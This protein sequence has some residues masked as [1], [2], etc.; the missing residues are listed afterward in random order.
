MSDEARGTLDALARDRALVVL[1][2]DGTLAPIVARRDDAA[3]R[4]STRAL[5]RVTSLLYPCAVVSGRSRADLAA[6]VE[7]VPLVAVV[8]NHGAEAGFGPVDR[9]E[10][11]T[12]AAWAAALRG[13]LAGTPGVEIEDKGLS[14]AIHHRQAPDRAAARAR[15]RAAAEALEGARVFLGRAVVNVVP[16]DAPDKGS[17]VREILRRLGVAKALYVGDDVADEDAFRADGIEVAI[18]IGRTH[19]SAAGW[20]LPAQPDIDEL[21]AALVAARRR[22]DGWRPRLSP[23]AVALV[24]RSAPSGDRRPHRAPAAAT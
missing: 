22:R 9:S 23:G 5:L 19:A 12:V 7:G 10:R 16:A 6:R 1:D 3:M 20:Y 24:T 8:G 2:F 18:R 4:P 15:A 17:A 14:V 11:D 21:L 13:R